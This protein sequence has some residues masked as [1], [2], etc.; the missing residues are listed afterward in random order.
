MRY[1]ARNPDK[2]KL[3]DGE[4]TVWIAEQCTNVKRTSKFVLNEPEQIYGYEEDQPW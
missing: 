4:S 2:A 3:R 1:I